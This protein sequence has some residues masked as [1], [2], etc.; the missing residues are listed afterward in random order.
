MTMIIEK[1]I[2]NKKPFP[3]IKHEDYAFFLN[4]LNQGNISI[5]NEKYDSICRIGKVSVSSNK[6]KSALWTWKIYREHEKLNLVKSCYYFFNYALRGI[7]K[8]Y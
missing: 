2:L 1:K 4:I 3:N 7:R 5:R 6:F 8:H